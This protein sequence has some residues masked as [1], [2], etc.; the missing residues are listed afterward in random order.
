MDTGNEDQ[1]PVF[2]LLKQGRERLLAED[3]PGAQDSLERA[4]ALGAK[5]PEVLVLLAAVHARQRDFARAHRR[6]AAALE[7]NSNDAHAH[8]TLGNLLRLEGRLEEAIESYGKAI[9]TNPRFASSMSNRALCL[10]DLGRFTLARASYIQAVETDPSDLTVAANLAALLFDLGEFSAAMERISAILRIEPQFS[11]A[12]VVKALGLLRRGE[13]ER[14]WTEYEWRDR[15]AG[16]ADPNPYDYPE[17]DGLPL[18]DDPL[19]VCAEQ[20]LGDQIMFASCIGDLLAIAP[21]CVIECDPRL[22]ALL[23][24]SFPSA[25]VYGQRTKSAQPWLKDGIVPRAKTWLGS[26]PLRF[27]RSQ[28][29]FPQRDA[30][31][32]ADP[33]KVHSWTQT[34]AALSPGLKVG[35]S[36][37][38]GVATTRRATRSIALSEW[39][40]ILRLP[41]MHV[42]SLQYGNHHD[43]IAG[44]CS[45]AGIT[46]HHWDNAIE[47]YDETAALVCAL[48]IVISVQTS[49]VHL[50]G[51]LG[52]P[53]WVL[54]PEIAEWRYGESADVM[55][56]YSSARLFRQRK[57]GAWKNVLSRVRNALEL[58]GTTGAR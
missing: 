22:T 50:A 34:L 43:E 30:H 10:Q 31:L 53:V 7:L 51:A 52:K 4:L 11:Q 45:G 47:N 46:I 38:G 8:D 42:V 24:R 13:Y 33:A 35:I 15:N 28:G 32:R 19:L 37:R 23:A 5:N 27:R 55:P 29:D 3:L 44:V 58:Q 56:W 26:L 54:V 1:L 12:H 36:W 18:R 16:R 41:R 48:D 6:L 39:L 20:G 40:P 25:R 9:V 14:G 2:A 21:R 17:W 57:T 49:I